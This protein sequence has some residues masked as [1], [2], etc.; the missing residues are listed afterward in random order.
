M[1]GGLDDTELSIQNKDDE[2]QP[3]RLK[4]ISPCFNLVY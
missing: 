1:E 2:I 4:G 3:K